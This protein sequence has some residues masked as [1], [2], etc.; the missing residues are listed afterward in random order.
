MALFLAWLIYTAVEAPHILA[1]AAA[2]PV[3]VSLFVAVTLAGL[4]CVPLATRQG[5]TFRPLLASSAII[6][7]GFGMAGAGMF[8]TFIP[9]T[10]EGGVSLNAFD[11]SSSLLTLT[12]MSCVAAVGVPLVIVY[13]S[14]IYWVFRGKVQLNDYHSY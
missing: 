6:F 10:L 3:L 12:V 13:T 5:K 8:P 7:G 1:M 11:H 2:R 9:T 14:A 4:V